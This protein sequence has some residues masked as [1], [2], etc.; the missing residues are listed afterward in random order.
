M[1]LNLKESQAISA[2]ARHLYDFLPGSGNTRTA[3]PLAAEKAGVVEYW[4]PGSKLPALS[5]LLAKTLEDRRSRFTELVLEIVRQSMTYR[6]GKGNPLQRQDII[7]LNELLLLV[8]FKI[9]ELNDAAFLDTM[10]SAIKERPVEQAVPDPIRLKA[11]TALRL[12]SELVELTNLEPHRRG[13][14]FEKFL[15]ELFDVS[16]LAARGAFRLVGEQIDGSFKCGNVFYLLEAKW[17]AG[18]ANQAD[19]LTFSGK[20]SG[21]AEWSRGL[22]V[23]YSG[24]S[25]DGLT[26]FATGRRTNLVCFDGLDLHDTLAKNLPLQE[27]IERK[28]RRA[29]ESNRAHVSVR[30]L[31]GF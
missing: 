29:A 4:E 8:S 3:F 6:Q 2:L 5:Q 13:F 17:L 12:T 26:A 28:S 30:D 11:E 19:L 10:P 16:G 22:F 23:S 25:A 20:V 15:S 31:F 9:P 24:F 7:R 1:A 27:V 21:K 18:H 14:A